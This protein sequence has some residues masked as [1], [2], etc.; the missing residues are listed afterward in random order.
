MSASTPRHLAHLFLSLL[1]L[2]WRGSTKQDLEN[3]KKGENMWL[4]L[5]SER[6][7]FACEFVQFVFLVCLSENCYI[8]QCLFACLIVLH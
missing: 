1:R 5:W 7:F 6:P 4:M 8:F 3:K 2:M